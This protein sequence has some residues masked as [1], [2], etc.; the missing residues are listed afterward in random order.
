MISIDYTLDG[1]GWANCKIIVNDQ[2]VEVTASYLTN[3][4]KDLIEGVSALYQQE[5]TR[6]SF[7]AEP[8]E[9]R[10]ILRN[11]DGDVDIRILQLDDA[12][13]PDPDEK[14]KLVFRASTAL[15]ELSAAVIATC[16]SLLQEHGLEGYKAKWI[17]YE[18]PEL[19]L[20][21]LK[22]LSKAEHTGAESEEFKP[23][24]RCKECHGTGQVPG[25]RK[26]HGKGMGS[27]FGPCPACDGIGMVTD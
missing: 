16:E 8:A 25:I 26:T 5:D 9:Y 1:A 27:E 22:K 13:N 18:F 23:R 10:W 3:A 2:W 14:G 21:K 20:D 11:Q 6:F 12:M 7:D 19:S 17:E 4:L 24:H 15:A